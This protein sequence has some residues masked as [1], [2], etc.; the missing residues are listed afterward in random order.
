MLR[1]R[2]AFTF[3]TVAGGVVF[4]A[5]RGGSYDAIARSE[6][7]LV[8][9]ALIALGLGLGILPRGWPGRLQLV[10]LGAF[11]ALT[12]LA[13]L[14]LAWTSNDEL[15]YSEVA[16]L[17]TLLGVLALPLLALNRYTWRAAAGGVVAGALALSAFALACR[18]APGVLPDDRVVEL[19]GTDRLSYPF[20]YWNAVGAWGAM[21]A[22]MGL[23]W[24]AHTKGRWPRALS[25][26]ALPFAVTCV[27][28]SYS[29]AG[30]IG[31]AVGA[32][33]VLC[34]SRNR[35]TALAHL[36]VVA[37]ASAAA[38]LVIR[39][40]PAIAEG[41]GGAGGI[42]VLA[43]LIAGAAA[44]A[45][46]AVGTA[47]RGLDR[48]RLEPGVARLAV[49]SLVV[50]AVIVG[51]V[52][53]GAGALGDAWDEFQNERT[54]AASDDPAARLTTAAGTRSDVWDEALDAFSSESLAGIGP[55]T[56]ETYWARHATTGEFLRDAHSLYLEQLAELGVL[57]FALLVA[58]LGSGLWACVRA[59]RRV[60]RSADAAA[61]ASLTA[62]FIV[63]L[64]SAGVDWMWEMTAV[65]A[66]ALL[67]LGVVLASGAERIKASKAPTAIRV[68][69][70]VVA[71]LAAISQVPVLVSTARVR[72]SAEAQSQRDVSKARQ[73]ASDAIAAEP[74]AATPYVQR[75]AVEAGAGN[76]S[77]AAAEVRSAIDREPDYWR[78]WFALVQVELEKGD[79]AAA[80]EAFD[81]LQ[82]LSRLS[83]V[84]WPT[85]ASFDQDPSLGSATRAGCLALTVGNCIDL[86][87]QARSVSG[88]F[89]PD[90]T[91]VDAVE[92][93][94]GG[95][96]DDPVAVKS[97]F[98][99]VP[100]YYV[101]ALADGEAG[102][103][104]LDA[105]AYR[106]GFGFVAPLDAGAASL[107]G[108]TK[109]AVGVSSDDEGAKAA[110]ECLVAPG[111]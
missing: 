10:P 92:T 89:E 101:T 105:S 104:A 25:L 70:V 74:W 85:L 73:L 14:S 102:T 110:Q 60:A 87:A 12:I 106:T 11:A 34:L 1:R 51:L 64:V 97:V 82:A 28:L 61:T 48:I 5:I 42:A 90:Q 18:L 65:T 26:A 71:S 21:A 67:A 76:F 33:A 32:I 81:R 72:E 37:A 59:R 16:R 49:P 17:F 29:R 77:A 9:W 54:I 39:G 83:M 46:V 27:Y 47:S 13:F 7:G 55:G 109:P 96:I 15:T 23:A 111:T 3:A 79:R 75:A 56:F 53:G 99:S 30:A 57:G 50:L 84:S 2:R 98:G 35:W 22:A 19:Y 62:A 58:A 41:T 91:A 40:E 94:R 80:S 63:Y 44:C 31:L 52:S 68:A 78:S 6:L 36:V 103:W 88:C 66:L 45:I 69:A 4:V 86:A 95:P 107:T 24:S 108:P 43:T 8:L 93:V 20:G 100:T 38:I